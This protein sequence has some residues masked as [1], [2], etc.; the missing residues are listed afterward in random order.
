MGVASQG[1]SDERSITIAGS[2]ASSQLVLDLRSQAHQQ[3]M[4]LAAVGQICSTASMTH[5]LA[6]CQKLVHK[7]VQAGAKVSLRYSSRR[8]CSMSTAQLGIDQS[9]NQHWPFLGSVPS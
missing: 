3:N 2:S 4:V 5:N 1:K 8:C 6:Q 7:A 9:L